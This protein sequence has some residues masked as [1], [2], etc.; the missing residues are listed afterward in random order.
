MPAWRSCESAAAAGPRSRSSPGAARRSGRAALFAWLVFE[1]NRHPRADRWDDP[2]LTRDLG[3]VTD[4]WA[5]WD[6]VWFLRIA[7]HGYGGIQHGAAAA[8]YP[9][10]PLTLAGVGRAFGGHYVA[11]GIVVSLGR[12]ARL[13]PAALPAGRGAARSRRRQAGGAVPR[14]VP[15]EP[16]PAGRL[17]RVALP[18]AR[19]RCVPARGAAAVARR[20]GG[21]RARSADADLRRRAVACSGNTCLAP[22]A[23]GTARAREPLRRAADLRGVPVVPRARPRRRVR[24]RAFA[25]L[26]EPPPLARRPARRDLG[27]FA[28][29][30]GR[31]SASS[32]PA[33]TPI[34]TG[35]LFATPTRCA[36]PPSTSSASCSCPP[37]SC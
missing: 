33:R 12:R 17:Q 25:G 31:A 20:G 6:S 24:V 1:P 15:D 2:T 21:H 27:R 10:Y 9:L 35:H 4:V 14:G 34:T 11:A 19:A 30:A 32:S 22:A 8:F 7:E 37:A 28:R 3:W 18:R 13:V 26:L 36:S 5:R 29:R 23:G 16:L